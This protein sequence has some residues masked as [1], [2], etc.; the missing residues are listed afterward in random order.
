MGGCR[1]PF[2]SDKYPS[3]V[4]ETP[5]IQRERDEV[6]EFR[7]Y[8]EMRKRAAAVGISSTVLV[9]E[10]ARPGPWRKDSP[11][12]L[13]KYSTTG[14]SRASVTRKNSENCRRSHGQPSRLAPGAD[15]RRPRNQRLAH[16]GEALGMIRARWASP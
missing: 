4:E 15:R 9:G 12:P 2:R 5:V 1:R 13:W 7:A 11:S 16:G 8:N 10:A 14:L 6:A 3:R